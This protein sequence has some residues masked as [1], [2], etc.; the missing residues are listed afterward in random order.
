[1]RQPLGIEY[2]LL[3]LLAGRPRHGYDIHQ[4]LQDPEG[5][6]LV[7]RLKQGHLYALLARLEE[8]DLVAAHVEMQ[9]A[10]P[11]RK[12]YSLTERGGDVFEAWITTPVTRGRQ[13]RLEF[14]AKLYLALLESEEAALRL[15]STQREACRTWDEA[16]PVGMAGPVTFPSLVGSFRASQVQASLDWLDACERMLR[17][18]SA[19]E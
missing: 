14:L 8:E 16:K 6:G 15:V 17:L 18:S 12:V 10:R 5:L 4:A 2:S 7:W 1:M 19:H 3:G 9:D 13:L 11:P